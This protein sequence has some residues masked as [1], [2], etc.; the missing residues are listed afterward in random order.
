MEVEVGMR[1]VILA[2]W[3]LSERGGYCSCFV[4]AERQSELALFSK[5]C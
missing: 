2:I 3:T 5:N 4:K 1:L